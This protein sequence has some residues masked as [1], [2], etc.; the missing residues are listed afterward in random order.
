M[1]IPNMKNGDDVHNRSPFEPSPDSLC[2]EHEKHRTH[3]C[4]AM[5]SC[6]SDWKEI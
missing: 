3:W 2:D 5:K 4:P 6:Y 1:E